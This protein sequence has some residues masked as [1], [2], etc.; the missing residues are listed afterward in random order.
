MLVDHWN[1]QIT[2]LRV[3]VTDRC[4]MR[5]VY[6][7]P[8]E[9]VWLKSHHEIM[10]YEEICDVVKVAAEH[11]LRAVRLT[12]GEPLVRPDLPRLVRMI[13][14]IAGI[15]D[16]SL[17]TN[18]VFLEHLAAPLAEAGLHRVNISLDTLDPVKYSRITR[19]GSLDKVWCGIQAAEEQGLQPIKINVVAMRGIND[20]EFIDL[21]RLSLTKP[22]H[23]RFIELMPI[24]NGASW[25]PDF[26][27]PDQIY[28]PVQQIKTILKP[29]GMEPVEESIGSGPAKEFRLHGGTGTIG[30]ISP[31]SEHFCKTCNRL[32][33]TADGNLR[34]C[35]LS[36]IEIPILPAL[37]RGEPILP[38][39]EK[40]LD[41]KPFR[42]ELNQS[43]FPKNRLMQEIGG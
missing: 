36:D 37:R 40:A 30:F 1:R 9:G 11:G 7:I 5:C 24:N 16:I 19:G 8:P 18:G 38:Y 42:H 21:A 27:P 4:N 32:R 26:P 31:L 20:D 3:S 2:Y 12:G 14:Q 22:W 41:L 39:L 13:A 34:P 25:G 29:M 23:I 17:T 6:C 33:L 43:R 28:I 35:L 15:Q 10:R